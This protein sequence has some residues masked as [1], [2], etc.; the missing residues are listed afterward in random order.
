MK[1]LSPAFEDAMNQ[2]ILIPAFSK[3]AKRAAIVRLC[4]LLKKAISKHG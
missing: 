4:Q 2:A 1:P 3:K